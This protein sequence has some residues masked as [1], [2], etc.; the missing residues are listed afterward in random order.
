[1]KRTKANTDCKNVVTEIKRFVDNS[2]GLQIV[3]SMLSDYIIIEQSLDQKRIT[4]NCFDL[5]EIL[6]REDEAGKAFLQV[7]FGSGKKILITGTLIGFRPL[8]LFGLDMERLPKVVTTPDIQS[9]FE[10][11]QEALHSTDEQEELDVL[12]KVYDS[13]ICGGES[14]GFD[15]KEERKTL[16]CIPA[17]VYLASA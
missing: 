17:R 9:V 8:G 12:R 14:V 4:I 13:V 15:L 1:M 2:E 10:A 6:Y 7:N 11:I 3:E 16:A 5:E